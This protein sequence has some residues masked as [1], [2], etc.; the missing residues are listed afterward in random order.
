M[1]AMMKYI[2]FDFGGTGVVAGGVCGGCEGA[3]VVTGGDGVLSGDD[4]G[5]ESGGF[6]LSIEFIRI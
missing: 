6:V 5:C 2:L 1:P 4:A 3:V